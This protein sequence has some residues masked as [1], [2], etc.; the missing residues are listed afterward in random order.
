MTLRGICFGAALVALIASPML[1]YA[2]GDV[3]RGRVI[4]ALAGGCGCHT[5]KEGPV[6]A[7]GEEIAT[8]FGKFFATNITPDEQTGIGTWSDDDIEQA[9]RGGYVRGRGAEAPVMPYYFYAGMADTDVADLIAFLRSLPPAARVNRA[10]EG[11]LPL[12]RLAY[13][14]WRLL[15]APMAS[16]RASAPPPGIERGRYLA[17]HVAICGDCHTP[18]NRLGVPIA[19]MYLAGT[20][21]GPGGD[22]VPNITSH[23]TGI[24]EWDADD[25]VN[26][27]TQGM[28]PNFDNIQGL[29]AAMVDGEGGGPGFKDAPRPALRDIA[30]YLKSVGAI[31][32][33]VGGK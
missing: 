29:M 26:V 6:G 33:K 25:V 9:I 8:P 14:A 19:S 24:G 20:D 1:A 30:V 18:R 7:G 15:F 23:A 10:H 16:H 3:E 28:L 5:P 12:A 21:N 32:N 11:E 13:R 2:G 4:F 31:D 17:D 27:L 22:P